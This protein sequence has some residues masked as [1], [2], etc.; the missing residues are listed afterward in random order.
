MQE[1]S[2]ND[3]TH[4][5][6]LAFRQ[7]LEQQLREQVR[8]AIETV[9]EAELT[10]AL[11]SGRHERTARRAG[12]RHGTVDRTLTTRD[13]VRQLRVP[14]GRVRHADGTTREFRSQLIPRYARRTREVDAAIL[15]SYLAG[16]NSRRIR[17]ALRPLLGDQH[18]SKSAV[19]R[20]VGRLKVL[21]AT[22]QTRPL[23]DERYA[24]LFL[25]GVHLKVR[26][27]R[28]VVAV[29]VLVALGGTLAGQK[30]LVALQ[31]AATEAAV[32]WRAVLTDLQQRGLPA[33]RLVVTDGH[34]GLKQALGG[35]GAHPGA[36]VYDPQGTKPR[37]GVSRACPGRSAAR[38]SPDHLRGRWVGGPR[39]L[40][41]VHQ[42]MDTALSARRPLPRGGR[43]R[44]ADVLR[45]PPG[46]VEVV[47]HDEQPG[48]PQSGIPATDE[49]A[50]L[51]QHRG[52][53]LD[54]ALRPGGR[55]P[56][57]LA[58]DRRAPAP[59]SLLS[60]GLVASRVTR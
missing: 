50:S 45:V 7:D 6:V 2:T 26:L 34:A 35:L 5:A 37:G 32:S 30:R 13:G 19:S 38:L 49:D 4:P 24:V 3:T 31:L 44:A 48:E 22:W 17:A 53:G 27:A 56:D 51:V 57:R 1:S 25:D 9:L 43:P 15:S 29:P 58:P 28:R 60:Q 33:P 10:A 42:E 41:R 40:R 59:P 16:A 8:E 21:F 47:A 14:R 11:G 55:W 54:V 23:P 20:I 36:A 12:Y 46:H 39:R 18:L 52:G